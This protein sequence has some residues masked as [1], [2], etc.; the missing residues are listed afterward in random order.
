MERVSG[1]DIELVTARDHLEHALD[2]ARLFTQAVCL[3]LGREALS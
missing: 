3:A 2:P 1:K